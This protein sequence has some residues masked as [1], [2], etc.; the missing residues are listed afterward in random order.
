MNITYIRG[1]AT[2]PVGEGPKIIVHICNDLGVWGA[3]FVLALSRR[4]ADPERVYREMDTYKLGSVSYVTV[5]KDIAV[6]NLIGQ[7]GVG[8]TKRGIPVRYWAIEEGLNQI[9]DAA[10]G[11]G[12]SIHMPRIGCGL[13]GG[14][15]DEIDYILERVFKDS[16][17]PVTV[18]DL[19]SWERIHK[20]VGNARAA[21][22]AR[23]RKN[24]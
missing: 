10:E 7:T 13:A 2:K 20:D 5:E 12:S 23:S 8:V 14:T 19:Y 6:A 1:D 18:Y 15:W 9:R 3:G 24:K 17:V 22:T 21:K 4:W 11:T 16:S